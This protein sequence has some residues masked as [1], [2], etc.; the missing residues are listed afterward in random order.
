MIDPHSSHKSRQ[1]RHLFEI[2]VICAIASGTSAPSAFQTA[3]PT[4]LEGEWHVV[5]IE[6]DGKRITDPSAIREMRLT[7]VGDTVIVAG[8]Y[9]SETQRCRFSLTDSTSPK[10]L[11]W[12]RPD[13]TTDRMLYEAVDKILRIAFS[14]Q[15]STDRPEVLSGA[16]GSKAIVMRLE[17]S[18]SK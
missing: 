1:K 7:F 6:R 8:L 5:A 18:G 9:G 4:S 13:G 16:P 2:I 11:D 10:R 14:F 12:T 3:R 17:R 15:G